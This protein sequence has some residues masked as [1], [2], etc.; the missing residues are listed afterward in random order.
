MKTKKNTLKLSVLFA[1]VTTL[2]A[3]GCAAKRP[4]LYPNAHLNEVGSITAQK[5]IDDCMNKAK[6]SVGKQ[7]PG[8]KIA[9]QT[10]YDAAIGAATG[11]AS[12]AVTHNAGIGAA[13]GAA[14]AGAF[15]CITGIFGSREPDPIF[16]Q[17]VDHCLRDKGYEPIG[18]R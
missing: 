4:V 14:G 5:D 17:F 18:W 7:I 12:G 1:L 9:K 10:A 16:T 15:G 6:E 8:E 11:A 13:T 2:I 3:A